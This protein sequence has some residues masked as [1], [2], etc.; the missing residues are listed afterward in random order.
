MLTD[1]GQY[2]SG[3]IA[4]FVNGTSMA[5]SGTNGGTFTLDA[6]NI[7]YNILGTHSLTLEVTVGGVPYNQTIEFEVLP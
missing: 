5:G 4:W 7:A 6:T 2:D 1:P 3:S